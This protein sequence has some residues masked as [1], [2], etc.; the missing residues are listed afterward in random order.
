MP[1]LPSTEAQHRFRRVFRQFLAAFAK[2]THPLVLLLDDLQ[3]IDSA[4]LQIIES[5]FTHAD[6]RYLLVI[7]AYRDNE[8]NA[9][10]PLLS[11]IK[12]I[13]HGG[14][15]VQEIVLAPL[16]LDA[17]NLLTADTLHTKTDTV[18]T[19]DAVDLSKD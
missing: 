1:E 3:W 2:S 19:A 6:T 18:R 14:M 11:S 16:P 7:G 8:V 10:H 15:P 5:L 12:A 17:L 9:A 4:S 13:R